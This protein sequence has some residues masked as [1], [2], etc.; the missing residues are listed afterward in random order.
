GDGPAVV[1]ASSVPVASRADTEITRGE[2]PR[3]GLPGAG[4][5]DA[6]GSW[7]VSSDAAGSAGRTTGGRVP[8]GPVGSA[9]AAPDVPGPVP[10][11]GP[12]PAVRPSCRSPSRARVPV[13]RRPIVSTRGPSSTGR[14]VTAL[15]GA[16]T[17]RP[18]VVVAPVPVDPLPP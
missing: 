11:T 3:R 18:V 16:S 15:Q 4:G 2:P 7:C 5:S 12:V 17:W 13:G 8:G 6:A 10:N 9:G 1:D 14:V